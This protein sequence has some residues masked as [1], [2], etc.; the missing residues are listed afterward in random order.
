M[1]IASNVVTS[2]WSKTQL[3]LALGLSFWP[4]VPVCTVR[5]LTAAEWTLPHLL[6]GTFQLR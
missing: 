2:G 1:T 5:S 4:V 3:L 6:I